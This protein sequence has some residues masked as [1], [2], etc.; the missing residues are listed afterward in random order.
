[1]VVVEKSSTSVSPGEAVLA[2]KSVG[3]AGG[4]AAATR[5]A[6]SRIKSSINARSIRVQVLQRVRASRDI[7][8]QRRTNLLASRICWGAADA[9][10]C[11]SCIACM[12]AA[13]PN[14][15]DL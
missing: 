8:R 9:R 2:Q 6:S 3:D 15:A 7:D 14:N 13:A 11:V 12:R 5:G 1:M 4:S 10:A